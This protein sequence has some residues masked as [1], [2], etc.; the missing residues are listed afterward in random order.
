MEYHKLDLLNILIV[1]P[2]ADEDF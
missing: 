2:V 1:S